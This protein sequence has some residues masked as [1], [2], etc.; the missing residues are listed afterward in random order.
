[1]QNTQQ[2]EF[3][4]NLVKKISVNQTSVDKL[5]S[6]LGLYVSQVAPKQLKAVYYTAQAGNQ[7]Q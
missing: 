5:A 1:L 3:E 7:I 4:L 2:N 6:S